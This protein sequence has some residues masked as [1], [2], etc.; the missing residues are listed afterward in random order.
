MFTRILLKATDVFRREGFKGLFRRV[1]R[2]PRHRKPDDFDHTRSVDTAAPVE[3]WQLDIPSRDWLAGVGYAPIS[4][5]VWQQVMHGLPMDPRNHWFADLGCGKGR[6]LILAAESGF[7]RV[8][9]VEFSLD[10]CR[11]ARRNLAKLNL[12][13]EILC[14]SARDYEFPRGS[15]VVFLY[16]PFGPSVL[17]PVLKS[18]PPDCYVVYVNP[19]HE[20]CVHFPLVH[21]RDGLRIYYSGA[22]SAAQSA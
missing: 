15:G 14:Q 20:S 6:A 13:A 11:I 5:E 10:L 1:F 9:G 22:E 12:N 8:I 16:N 19:K 21:S 17:E 7:Q 18:V 2:K 4:L 3:L